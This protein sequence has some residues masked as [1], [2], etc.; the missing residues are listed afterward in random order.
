MLGGIN[1]VGCEKW[2]RSWIDGQKR[3]DPKT[4]AGS[5]R[6]MYPYNGDVCLNDAGEVYPV[7]SEYMVYGSSPVSEA[8][9]QE[10]NPTGQSATVVAPDFWRFFPD[11]EWNLDPANNA[12]P[13][14]NKEKN[15]IG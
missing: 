2:L 5:P 13:N 9:D 14:A 6:K 3:Y 8:Y 12:A 4:T 10:G 15:A 1:F 11:L 7:N